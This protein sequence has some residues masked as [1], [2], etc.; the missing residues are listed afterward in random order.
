MRITGIQDRGKSFNALI[1]HKTRSVDHASEDCYSG[2]I[3][4]TIPRETPENNWRNSASEDREDCNE[5]SRDLV[6]ERGG[7]A[8]N[9][10]DIP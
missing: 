2:E 7:I 9:M 10:A 5:G 6:I 8:A 4:P 3:G 1:I